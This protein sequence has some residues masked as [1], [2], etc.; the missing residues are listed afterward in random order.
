MEIG[1]VT[2]SYTEDGKL[3]KDQSFFTPTMKV[4][5]DDNLFNQL[6]DINT[7]SQRALKE[8]ADLI[9]AAFFTKT[10]DIEL[11]DREKYK[12]KSK[13]MECVKYSNKKVKR[14][15]IKYTFEKVSTEKLS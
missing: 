12:I 8:G 7:G 4:V 13:V 3:V 14:C 15:V 2:M 5:V 9:F 11:A 10:N 6:I 1:N